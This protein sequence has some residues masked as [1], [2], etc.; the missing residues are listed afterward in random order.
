MCIVSSVLSS[1][2]PFGLG[3]NKRSSAFSHSTE[4][5]SD[6]CVMRKSSVEFSAMA[7]GRV[8]VKVDRRHSISARR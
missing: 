1:H 7:F 8:E 5:R 4:A 2:G 6:E 3:A